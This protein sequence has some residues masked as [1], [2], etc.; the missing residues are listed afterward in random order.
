MSSPRRSSGGEGIGTAG[1]CWPAGF[2]LVQSWMERQLQRS[3]LEAQPGR[4]AGVPWGAAVTFTAGQVG[5]RLML[6]VPVLTPRRHRTTAC[7]R[8]G[9]LA[10]RWC[11]RPL[12]LPLTFSRQPAGAAK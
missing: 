4:L 7:W 12:T 2:D 9:D 1:L 5:L 6:P 8:A 3:V 11:R 10:G